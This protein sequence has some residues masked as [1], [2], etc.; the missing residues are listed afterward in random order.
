MTGTTEYRAMSG[1]CACFI[2]CK[3][4]LGCR[5]LVHLEIE[6]EF[7]AAKAMPDIGA[8]DYKHDWLVLLERDLAAAWLRTAAPS[9]IPANRM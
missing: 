4:R 8:S 9:K 3:A 5:A 2:G 7:T 6:V 1:E